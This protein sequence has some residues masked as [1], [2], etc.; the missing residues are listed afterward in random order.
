MENRSHALMAGLFVVLL[1]IAAAAAAIWISKKNI[2]LI[3]YELV[4]ISPVTG[5]SVQSQVRYQGVPVGRVDSLRFIQDKPGQVRIMIGVDPNTPITDGT[6]GEIATAGVTGISNIELRDNGSSSTRVI[7]SAQNI[8]EIPMRPGFWERLQQQGGGMLGTLERI[9]EQVEKF[10]TAENAD[11]LKSALANS[12]KLTAELSK[13]AATIEP[14]L[15]KLPAMM[16]TF[17]TTARKVDVAAQQIAMLATSAQET[18]KM[19]NAPYGPMQ[20]ASHSL[21]SIQQMAAQVRTS[22]LPDLSML[23]DSMTDAARSVTHTTRVLGQ[24]PQ[25]LIFGPPQVMAGPGE[26]GFAG[27]GARSR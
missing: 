18:V 11:S 12:A 27:F 8:Q 10:T 6:W 1:S 7:S 9:M 2:P 23:S 26:P 3:P 13:A 14:A 24:S 17:S 20:M 15:K 21:Q 22:T 25:S 16:D 19:L 5:L 4:S